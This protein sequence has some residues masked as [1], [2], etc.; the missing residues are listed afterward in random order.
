[1]TGVGR[2]ALFAGVAAAGAGLMARR[3]AASTD[4]ALFD[5]GRL[6]YVPGSSS[7]EIVVLD[8]DAGTI[9]GRLTGSKGAQQAL[10]SRS[11]GTLALTDGRTP[12]IAAVDVVGNTRKTVAIPHK[13]Q[14]LTLSASG[15]LV[16]ASDLDGGSIAI[17]DLQQGGVIQR[18]SGLPPLRDAMFASGDAA[19]Y[20]AAAGLGGVGVIDLAK[21][22]IAGTLPVVRNSSTDV[23]LLA[24]SADGQLIFARPAQGGPIGVIDA[25]Q[26]QP[27][28]RLDVGRAAAGLFP[29]GLGNYLLVPDEDRKALVVFRAGQLDKPIVLPGAGG[30][31]GVYTTWLD[32]VAFMPNRERRS[33]LVYDLDK[34]QLAGELPLPGAPA[35]G[36][37]TADTRTLYLPI[38]GN[39]QLLA[40]D[41]QTRRI[42]G[43]VGL[44]TQPLAALIAGGSGLCH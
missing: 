27:L 43:A 40:L 6:V 12:A 39:P 20:V 36:A 19:I 41:G 38:E 44:P 3:A 21:G 10:L 17:V 31:T 32:S 16:A 35:L 23:D 11:T 18:I 2:R 4:A 29:S 37:V 8:Q 7:A 26:K 24:R 5:I 9:A 28:A 15:Q 42:R 14:R 1:V 13:A 33:V 25:A 34:M 30:A 22:R